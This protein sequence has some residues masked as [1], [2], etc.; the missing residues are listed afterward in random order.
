MVELFW[1]A[2]A[3]FAFGGLLYLALRLASAFI[4]V[5]SPSV[6]EMPASLAGRLPSGYWPKQK[7]CPRASSA[8]ARFFADFF[9]CLFCGIAFIIFL[10]WRAD[11]I[12]RMFVFVSAGGGAYS[13]RRFLSPLVDCIEKWGEWIVT[14]CFLW[15]SVPL[16]RLFRGILSHLSAFSKKIALFFI[17]RA[18]RFYTICS[19]RR[20]L[21]RTEKDLADKRIASAIRE[22]T[23]GKGEM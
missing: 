9:A 20:Y 17:K 5:F 10:F 7:D 13:A 14:F 4:R 22:A 12:P 19:A 2:C 18:K 8:L 3:A 16:I 1:L 6:K 21:V 23:I 15:L 11:G